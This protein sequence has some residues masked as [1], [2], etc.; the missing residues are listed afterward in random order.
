MRALWQVRDNLHDHPGGDTV[1][2]VRVAEAIRSIGVEVTIDP[3][4]RLDPTGF[5]LLHLFH[6]DRPWEN[7]PWAE[8]AQ[9]AGVPIAVSSIW[10]PQD[11]FDAKGRRGFQGQLARLLGHRGYASARGVQRSLAARLKGGP[12]RRIIV[13]A[14]AAAQRLLD[15]ATV[16][17]P[18]SPQEADAI[19]KKFSPVPRCIVVP[20][21]ADAG[22]YSLPDGRSPRRGVLCVGRLEPRKNQ[23]AVLEALRGLD[24][25]VTFIGGRG[26]FSG[27][28][29]RR[30]D[31]YAGPGVSIEEARP[32]AE[33][34]EAYR[35]SRVH[36]CASW[37][38]TPGLVSLEAAL[39]G[40]AIVSTDRGS[41]H[42]Y[43]GD[44]AFYCDPRRPA[45]IRSAVESALDRGPSNQL[46]DR[47]R[48]RFNWQTA[49][50]ATA[51]A[52][53]SIGA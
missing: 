9:N 20:N 22:T 46:A 45:S 43:L 5:D 49:A 24:E 32:P 17:L 47:I 15:L 21:A 34:A 53:R 26:R 35:S 51:D 6:L 2:V 29:A 33:L 48:A 40:C 25:P 18:N 10:W 52:Y 7:I 39:C 27:A 31:G 50:E 4:G 19:L 42:W 16:V 44:D 37:Y 11:E 30:L 13:R 3:G 28:Y 41:P 38:E 1:Q 14:Y 23:L 12:D 36:V 8:R